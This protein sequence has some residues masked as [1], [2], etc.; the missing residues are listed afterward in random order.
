MKHFLVAALAAFS[1]SAAEAQDLGELVQEAQLRLDDGREASARSILRQAER[2]V[3]EDT[4][5]AARGDLAFAWSRYWRWRRQWDRAA[6]HADD[7]LTLLSQAG[8]EA[9]VVAN[10]AYHT[11]YVRYREGD[12]RSANSAFETAVDIYARDRDLLDSRRLRANGW[13]TLTRELADRIELDEARN[14]G[15]IFVIAQHAVPV[16]P[17]L[18]AIGPVWAQTDTPGFDVSAWH[19]RMDGFVVALVDAGPDGEPVNLRVL[20]S[21]PGDLWDLELSYALR[22]WR[23]DLSAPDVRRTDIPVTFVWAVQRHQR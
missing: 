16:D 14:G 12:I 20:E 6:E 19:G 3:T 4:E 13:A 21:H 10:V 18:E 11:G 8:A 17:G 23:L 15:G 7:A 1:I 22:T 5:A 9:D 2:A